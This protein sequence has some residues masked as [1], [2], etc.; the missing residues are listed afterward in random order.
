MIPAQRFKRKQIDASLFKN[1]ADFMN[2]LNDT[3]N[4]I[5]QQLQNIAPRQKFIVRIQTAAVV[6]DAFPVTFAN[7]GFNMTG[8]SVV[9]V[10]NADDP[11]AL[12]AGG[13]TAQWEKT[14]SGAGVIRYMT[15]LSANT[16]YVVELEAIGV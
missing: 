5:Y 9:K 12:L 11:N 3:F 4:D 13:V 14:T 15:G 1:P 16:R 10:E 8:L 2:A 7:P 6:A